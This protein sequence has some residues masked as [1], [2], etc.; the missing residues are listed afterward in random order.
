MEIVAPLQVV[1]VHLG[2]I[3]KFLSF[4]TESIS[5][6]VLCVHLIL[7]YQVVLVHISEEP[8]VFAALKSTM[9]SVHVASLLSFSVLPDIPKLKTITL[10]FLIYFNLLFF[11]S[12]FSLMRSHIFQSMLRSGKCSW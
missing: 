3:G 4:F 9:V 6:A 12:S 5:W 10:S 2:Q 1:C 8:A 11:A 7:G